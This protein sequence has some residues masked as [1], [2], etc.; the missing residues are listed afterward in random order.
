MK[1]RII[2]SAIIFLYMFVSGACRNEQLEHITPDSRLR[3]SIITAEEGVVATRAGEDATINNIYVLVFDGTGEDAKL[4]GWAEATAARGNVYY[5]T[6]SNDVKNGTMYVFANIEAALS[7]GTGFGEDVTLGE[8]KQLLKVQLLMKDGNIIQIP[9][10]APMVGGPQA[11]DQNDPEVP[12]FS[13]VRATAK[14]TVRNLSGNPSYVIEGAN[15]GKAPTQG[16]V[17]AG[18]GNITATANYAGVVSGTTYSVENM[19]SGIN[20]ENA[21]ETEPLYAFESPAANGTFAIIKGEYSGETG[22]HRLDLKDR[23]GNILEIRRN[24]QYIININKIQTGGYRTAEEAMKNA[25]SNRDVNWSV[26]VI[27]PSSHDIVTNGEQYLGV[28][29]SALILYRSGDLQ[30]VTATS[31]SYTT[32][33]GWLAGT[34]T[35]TGDGL[36][37]SEATGDKKNWTMPGT[38]T[39]DK[40]ININCSAAFTSGYLVFRIGD[41]S[42]IVKIIR[43]PNLPAIPDEM[44]FDN[45]SVGDCSQSGS[46]KTFIRFADKSGDY[47]ANS[48]LDIYNSQTGSL[49][50]L[51]TANAGYQNNVAERDG[52]FYVSSGKDAGRTKVVFH[53]EKIDV[54]TGLVQIQPYTYVGTFHRWNQTGERIVRINTVGNDPNVKWTAVVVAGQDFIELSD[55]KSPDNGITTYPYGCNDISNPTVTDNANWKT[56]DEVEANCQIRD[57]K[58]LV[59]G[60]G[61]TIYFRVGLKS[62]LASATS[63]PRYGLIA[64]IHKGGNHLIYVRQGEEADYLMRP[65]DPLSDY[66]SASRANA[67]KISPYNLTVPDAHKGDNYYDLPLNGGEWTQYPSQGG[68]LFK[69]TGECRAYRMIGVAPGNISL[70]STSAILDVCPSGFRLPADIGGKV[71]TSEMRQSFWL[72]PQEGVAS[73]DYANMLRGYIADGFFDRRPI[74]IPN[75]QGRTNEGNTGIYESMTVNGVTYKIPT[76]VDDGAYTGFAGVLAYNPTTNASIFIPATGSI[77]ILLGPLR[78]RGT[79]AESNFWSTTYSQQITTYKYTLAI[80]YYYSYQFVFDNYHASPGMNAYSLRCVKK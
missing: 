22:Y 64:L 5:A 18:V 11:Y 35:A 56:D 69:G 40:K 33:S 48:D 72:Y 1:Y 51:V 53:Q 25:A 7:G 32:R 80:G 39:K 34:V 60:H 59:T 14:V 24:Y 21:N 55:E 45:L 77:N 49:Y 79:G 31:V 76:L 3:F 46:M 16:Y 73:S 42:K 27:D 19:I 29:N 67:V 41:L 10:F 61:N 43:N 20:H 74:R 12:A 54:Y 52:E 23:D 6:L 63:Q 8:L 13:L 62:K 68:H 47:S 30:N 36:T 4:K 9:R 65:A 70:G 28:S 37:L 17:F 38:D 75:T 58:L 15:L 50:A 44:K 57:G 78:T 2:W 26:D 71:S 66:A